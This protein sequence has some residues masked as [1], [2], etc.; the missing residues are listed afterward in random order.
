MIFVVNTLQ[1]KSLD[2]NN[3]NG[4]HPFEQC[5]RNGI[6]KAN[7][8]REKGPLCVGF[9]VPESTSDIQMMSVWSQALD[10]FIV[11][12]EHKTAALKWFQSYAKS[13]IKKQKTEGERNNG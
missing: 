5:I 6:E 2:V 11:T 10:F 3:F 13:E 1:R 8:N 7:D 12:P 4:T 9:N